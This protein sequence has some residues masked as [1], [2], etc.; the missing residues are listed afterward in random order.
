MN[1]HVESGRKTLEREFPRAPHPNIQ[2]LAA[3]FNFKD[4]DSFLAALGRGHIR[5][6]QIYHALETQHETNKPAASPILVKRRE[7]KSSGMNIAGISDLLTRIARCCKPIPGDPIVGFIT[8]G[9]G[10]TIHKKTCNNVVHINPQENQRLLEVTWDSGH[11]GAYYVDLQIRAHNHDKL[12]KEIT[13]VLSNAKVN[14]VN[15]NSAVNRN[16]MLVITITIQIHALTQ[17]N[18]LVTHINHLKGV[19]DS[20]RL[21]Q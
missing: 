14:L 9:S 12:L 18:E 2:K 6:A 3:H 16:N 5:M 11:T 20:R 10:V 19:I 7:S 15:F 21:N 1:Q 8:Q 4:D 13:T 17:L